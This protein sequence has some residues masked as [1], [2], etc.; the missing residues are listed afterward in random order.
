MIRLIASDLDGTLLEPV[1]HLP[2]GLFETLEKLH[3]LG[4][5]F[6]AASGR[7]YDNLRRLFAPAAA[8]MGFICE[9]GALNVLGGEAIKLQPIERSMA[10]DL[11]H[12]LQKMPVSIL[13]SGRHC[14]Y[15]SPENRAFTDDI[16]YRLRNTTAVVEHLD[17]LADEYLKISV[18]SPDGVASFAKELEDA[19]GSK[20]H[21]LVSGRCWFDFGTA[22][23]AT[24]IHALMEKLQIGKE[25]VVAF[26]DQ[27]N[28]VSMLDA[29]GHPFIMD[30]ASDALKSRGYHLCHKVLP[31]LQYIAD[32]EGSLEG[33]TPS[34]KNC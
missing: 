5:V 26:G 2:D 19:W 30:T 32:H 17:Q 13:V 34:L 12:H 4:I 27:F 33:Y 25:E 29:V 22:S 16:I 15:V 11:I 31:V 18:F 24:G 28:D 7:Q 21:A 8:H 3:S 1:E 14:C 6:A 23:K 10:L 9:N 20:L